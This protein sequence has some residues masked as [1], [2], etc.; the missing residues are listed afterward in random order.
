M[1]GDGPIVALVGQTEA[2]P[3]GS[4]AVSGRAD[5]SAAVGSSCSTGLV[6]SAV[7]SPRLIGPVE[8]P[9]G[10]VDTRLATPPARSSRPTRQISSIGQISQF[11]PTV[12]GFVSFVAWSTLGP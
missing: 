10:E 6:G 5:V 1:V 2:V 11:S 4:K 7:P 9:D 8:V 3:P 12:I